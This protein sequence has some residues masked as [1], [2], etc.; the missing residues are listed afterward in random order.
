M[1][2]FILLVLFFSSGWGI[3]RKWKQDWDN[4]SKK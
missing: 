1:S 3:Y 4:K 2:V